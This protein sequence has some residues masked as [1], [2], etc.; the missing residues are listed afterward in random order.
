MRL[1]IFFL[2]TVYSGSCIHPN[3]DSNNSNIAV[4]ERMIVQKDELKLI[5]NQGLVYFK[6]QP[7]TGISELY[8][9]GYNIAERITYKNGQKHGVFRKWFANGILSFEANY[10]FGK[11]NGLVRS[12][13]SNGNIRSESRFKNGI[14]SGLQKQWYK[15]GNRFKTLNIVDGREEG[16][17]KAWR[18]NGKLY[19]NYQAK[20]GRIFG[21]KRANLCYELEKEIIQYKR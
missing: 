9:D 11:K 1:F 19:N 18:E 15:S 6:D 4:N 12:W 5:P 13:W 8:Y 2:I 3:N 17:Q 14:V 21:L 16:M 10:S 7:F 20:N